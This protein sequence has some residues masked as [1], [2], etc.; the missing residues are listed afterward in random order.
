MVEN[1]NF[2]SQKRKNSPYLSSFLRQNLFFKIVSFSKEY[3]HPAIA[4]RGYVMGIP[5]TTT[6]TIRAICYWL[7]PYSTGV[8]N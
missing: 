1:H 7:H 3:F 4:V 2:S 6:L 8:N 5:G